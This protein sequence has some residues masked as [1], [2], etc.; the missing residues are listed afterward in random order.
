[1]EEKPRELERRLNFD[2]I[3]QPKQNNQGIVEAYGFEM[4]S[5]NLFPNHSLAIKIQRY[6]SYPLEVR[7]KIKIRIKEITEQRYQ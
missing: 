4:S 2:Y 7:Q 3:F 5:H 1:M 6:R